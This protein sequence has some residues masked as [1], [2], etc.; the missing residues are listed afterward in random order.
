MLSYEKKSVKSIVSRLNYIIEYRCLNSLETK[1]IP[2][3]SRFK[4]IVFLNY[5]AKLYLSR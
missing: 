4:N 5:H 1:M 3:Q 2:A